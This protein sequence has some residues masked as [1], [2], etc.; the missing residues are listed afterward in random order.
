MGRKK[1]EKVVRKGPRQPRAARTLLKATYHEKDEPDVCSACEGRLIFSAR[2]RGDG[3]CGPCSRL[4]RGCATAADRTMFSRAWTAHLKQCAQCFMARPTMGQALCA[5]GAKLDARTRAPEPTPDQGGPMSTE[6]KSPKLLDASAIDACRRIG[7]N[8]ADNNTVIGLP[9]MDALCFT[10][11]HYLRLY[12]R[13]NEMLTNR[14]REC[15]CAG[16]TSPC[17]ACIETARIQG[18]IKGLAEGKEG[19]PNAANFG[20]V[21]TRKEGAGPPLEKCAA[22]ENGVTVAQ[23]N[24]A[25][26]TIVCE[27]C[28][29][30]GW[31]RIVQM[32]TDTNCLVCLTAN[33]LLYTRE[34]MKFGE[35]GGWKRLS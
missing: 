12:E 6:K 17:Y 3:L 30:T 21:A 23:H 2:E 4:A 33:G 8:E 9:E 26:F 19:P 28:H 20:I 27:R 35:G 32:V 5:L 25:V 14:M 16:G 10:A 34:P 11:T 1:Q 18:T 22:C 29:G 24:D 7:R 15:F 13:I 31:D